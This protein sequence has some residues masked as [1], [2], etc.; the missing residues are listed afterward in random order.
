MQDGGILRGAGR[1]EGEKRKK[2]QLLFCCKFQEVTRID[3]AELVW[4]ISRIVLVSSR[5]NQSKIPREGGTS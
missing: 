2:T 1:Q 5:A 3:V 4:D